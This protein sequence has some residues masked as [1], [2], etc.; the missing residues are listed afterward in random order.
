MSSWVETGRCETSAEN[1]QGLS[2]GRKCDPSNLLANWV[3]GMIDLAM[4][5]PVR[6]W[7]TFCSTYRFEGM[8][9]LA[10]DWRG[11]ADY[12]CRSLQWLIPVLVW[13]ESKSS[14]GLRPKPSIALL[15]KILKKLNKPAGLVLCRRRER[16]LLQAAWKA[17]ACAP[18][19]ASLMRTTGSRVIKQD[20]RKV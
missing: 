18:R 19:V 7:L 11:K 12:Y 16:R 14:C 10:V 17:K 8:F 3:F 13:L 15:T 2:G 4:A 9:F 1:P 6:F 20:P 5:L